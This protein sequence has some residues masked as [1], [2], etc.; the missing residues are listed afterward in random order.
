MLEQH[1]KE[2]SRGSYMI[3]P[4]LTFAIFIHVACVFMSTGY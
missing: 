3:T 4:G 2:N 1:F